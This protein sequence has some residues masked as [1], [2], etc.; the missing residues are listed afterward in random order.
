MKLGKMIVLIN[1][2]LVKC[3][4]VFLGAPYKKINSYDQD[5]L[6]F[7]FTYIFKIVINFKNMT[8]S[9]LLLTRKYEQ[10]ET[11]FPPGS[12]L[13]HY[14]L[15]APARHPGQRGPLFESSVPKGHLT[16]I[17]GPL[18]YLR[19]NFILTINS[20]IY[21]DFRIIYNLGAR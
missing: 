10:E 2:L 19:V 1:I 6:V 21:C 4:F 11:L 20:V 16:Q 17:R 5:F 3:N 7:C 8:W 9:K 18:K 15:F 12:Y 14:G 13:N